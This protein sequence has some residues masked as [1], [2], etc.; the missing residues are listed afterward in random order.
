[1]SKKAEGSGENIYDLLLEASK[2]E[3]KQK[4]A[5][6]LESIGIKEYFDE[7]SVKIDM[8]TCK[9]LECNLC[10]EAC[11]TNALYWKAGEIGLV[12]DLCVYCAAC[13]F[14]CIVDNCIHVKRKRSNGKMEE[15]T[16][17][18]DVLILLHKISSEKRS[19][20]IKSIFP[21]VKDYLERY[22]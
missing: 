10:V 4:R 20:R 18:R 22:G 13:V 3:K 7:G 5:E 12:E 21:T 16:T 1:M 2:K 8:K 14:N 19:D 9:G 15:F 6:L 11:P 17:P